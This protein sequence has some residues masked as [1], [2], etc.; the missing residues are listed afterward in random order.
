MDIMSQFNLPKY[1]KGKSFSEA[2]KCIADKFQDRNSPEDQATLKELQGRLRSAQEFVKAKQEA[3]TQPQGEEAMHQMPDGTMMPGA[4]HGEETQ[5]PQQ[6]QVDPAMMQAMQQAMP[7]Q[8]PE[9]SY[10]N[11]GNL[12]EDGGDKGKKGKTTQLQKILVDEGYL[13]EDDVDGHWGDTTAA[14]YAKYED[15][16]GLDRSRPGIVP[17]NV[18]SLFND[19]TGIQSTIDRKSLR[20]NQLEALQKIVRGNLAKGVSVIDYPDYNTETLSNADGTGGEQNSKM[21]TYDKMTDPNFLLKTVVGRAKIMVTPENDTLVMDQYNFNDNDGTGNLG[22]M[23][24]AIE[25]NGSAYNVARQVGTNYGS[26]EGEGA[27]V[28]I[29]TNEKGPQRELL[30]QMKKAQENKDNDFKHGG[31]MKKKGNSYEHGGGHVG[32]YSP[33]GQFGQLSRFA[34]GPNGSLNRGLDTSRFN[35]G[36]SPRMGE[37][38]SYAQLDGLGNRAQQGSRTVPFSPGF[39]AIGNAFDARQTAAANK[40]KED[41]QLQSDYEA[42]KAKLSGNV[43]TLQPEGLSLPGAKAIADQ[44]LHGMTPGNDSSFG[45]SFGSRFGST[46]NTDIGFESTM[47]KG[48]EDNFGGEA[49]GYK[50]DSTTFSGN[51]T[52]DDVNKKRASKFNPG[53]LLRYAA[54]AS[55]A[56]QLANLKKP[57]DVS[58]GRLT[59]KYDEQFV[60]EKAMQNVVEGQAANTRSALQNA[61]GGSAAALRANLLGAQVQSQGAMSQAYNQA[62]AENRNERRQGQQFNSAV[63]QANMAQADK[64]TEMNLVQK[65]GYD[66]NR[67]RLLAQLGADA[68]GIGQE[69]LFKRFP[70]LA[71]LGYDYKGRKIKTT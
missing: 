18:K 12:Y 51:D 49:M 3:A 47:G 27:N 55:T 37:D 65:A 5:Q 67:S 60:D 35:E 28:L 40:A 34:M 7:Q 53:E 19:V 31:Y 2:S 68:S 4:T 9:N 6:P 71:G 22:K 25:K 50:S 58:L 57:K 10:K 1:L 33:Y 17:L 21:S 59:D 43:T 45:R 44:A 11:G 62:A 46:P 56:Y 16:F 14:A 32:E 69:E 52:N 36:L 29:N 41:A 64:E 24:E 70:E 63:N 13:T 42:R 54:P 26:Q 23:M 15:A 38:G 61:S 48:K 39:E 8:G 30:A 20:P 66:T